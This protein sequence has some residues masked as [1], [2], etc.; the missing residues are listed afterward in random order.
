MAVL[1][2]QEPQTIKSTGYCMW[3]PYLHAD[4]HPLVNVGREK[5]NK[6]RKKK[7]KKFLLQIK[8]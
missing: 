1:K 7:I 2:S 3:R 8:L 6:I 4:L 5:K